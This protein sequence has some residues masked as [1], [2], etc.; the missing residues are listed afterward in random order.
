MQTINDKRKVLGRGL[1]ALLP[2]RNTAAGQSPMVTGEQRVNEQRPGDPRAGTPGAG[3][4]VYGSM[5]QEIALDLI[6]RNPYQTRGKQDDES[7]QELAASIQVAGVIQ[8]IIVRPR[9]N[10]RYQLMAGERRWMASERAGK[11]TIP[12]VVRAASNEQAMEITIIENLQRED[13]NPMEQARAY[14]RLSREFGLTQEQIAQRTGKD[15]PS[16]A[17]FLRLMKLPTEVQ[18]AM[19]EGSITFGHGKVLMM[20][21]NEPDHVVEK[22]ARKVLKEG[23]LVRATEELVRNLLMAP[24]AREAKAAL[25]PKDA[26]VRQAEFELQK[27]LG[28]RVTIKDR[29]G[30]GKIILE[31]ANLEDFDRVLEMVGKK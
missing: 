9:G 31:Y 22:I 8:P 3:A 18:Q 19:E 16:V 14:E 30:K 2:S 12:A 15:R 27:A 17:N 24:Q 4:G 13:L 21:M 20:L 7:L 28:C 29:G 23:L 11:K 6:D 5:A 26:N 25:K 1:D 10:G